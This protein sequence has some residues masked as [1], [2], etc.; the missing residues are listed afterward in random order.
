MTRSTTGAVTPTGSRNQAAD[1]EGSALIVT[2]K[3]LLTPEEAA[4][5]LSVGRTRVYELIRTGA[6]GSVRIGSSRR[7]PVAAVESFVARLRGLELEGL[8]PKYR[9]SGDGLRQGPIG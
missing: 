3:V 5:A 7:V 6:L 9:A 4:K 1:S 2:A 8:T